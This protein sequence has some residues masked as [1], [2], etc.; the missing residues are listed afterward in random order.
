MNNSVP[1]SVS[2][3]NL[4]VNPVHVMDLSFILPGLIIVSVL[5]IRKKPPG[6]I[7]VPV[8][9]VFIIL[10]S[11]ALAAMTIMLVLRNVS[12]DFSLAGI[13]GVLAIISIIFLIVLLKR[14]KKNII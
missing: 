11:L 3:Y 12:E 10:L 8:F 9:L 1:A 4:L 14:L 13:F 7:F 6:Y 5:L 2:S